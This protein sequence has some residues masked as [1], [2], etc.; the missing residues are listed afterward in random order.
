MAGLGVAAAV[1]ALTTLGGV[2]TASAEGTVLGA[3]QPGAIKDSYIV[4]LKD[5][6]TAD[7][8]TGRSG[9]V[10][11]RVF[12]AALHGYSAKMTES[13]ARRVAA[14]PAVA[15]VEQNGVLR[16]STDQLNPPS[17]GQDR[18]DQRDLPLDSKYSYNSTASNVTAYIIDTGILT[19]H[20]DF[21]GRASSGYDFVDNDSNATDCNG[22]GTHVAGTV[23]GTAHGLAKEAKLV[24]VR[25][26]DCGG[27]GSYEGVIAGIDWVTQNAA[28][29]AVANM[30]LGGGA[31]TAVDNAVRRSITAG[32]T[33][34]LAAG[35]DNGASACN[36][37]PA[38]TQEAI[39]VAST[40][41]TDARSSFSNIGTCV[42]IFAPGSSIK[43]A[44]I[45]GNS[46]TNTISGTSMAT[47]H[48]VGAAAL[49]L[50]ANPSATPQQVRDAL[51]NNGTKNKV[52]NP[53]S[54]SPNVLL[55]T[56]TAGNEP[57]PTPCG[58]VSNAGVLPIPDAGEAV[59]SGVT[60][61]GCARS[62]SATT[63][64]EVHIKHTYR[65]DLVIDLVAPDGTAYRLQ[66]ASSDS[67]DNVDTT[68]EVNASGEAA[69]GTWL[70]KVQD[71]YRVDT[72]SL[73]SWSLTV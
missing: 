38:R 60:V 48:V 65:G 49:Y 43:S 16:A 23:G 40:T 59:T 31:S 51:V 67:A 39:T 25:V 61:A 3:G 10:V 27:S 53:G 63:K 70:L 62:A 71:V 29:P 64:A 14:D 32:I 56:G 11:Q 58:T 8:V 50:A 9:G 57:E 35:N 66:N 37:S 19:T 68:Y 52:T 5:G 20:T 15:Y 33:Y 21:G 55:Y 1:A 2:G 17:W 28:K 34:G 18:V 22:H 24:A 7:Q 73:T 44:W 30:S 47:P 6:A 42:D 13:Q 4:A 26:L 36:S 72:G 12:S 69:N 54:G 45:G 41:N 46:A